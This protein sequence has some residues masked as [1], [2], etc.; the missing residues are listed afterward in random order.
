MTPRCECIGGGCSCD[1]YGAGPASLVIKRE[2]EEMKVCSRCKM[3][4]DK[5]LWIISEASAEECF[6]YDPLIML[7]VPSLLESGIEAR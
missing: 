3:G 1:K 5:I 7:L 4:D 2:G 6:E